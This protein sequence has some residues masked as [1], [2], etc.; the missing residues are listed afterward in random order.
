[1][2]GAS[3]RDARWCRL[4]QSL[5]TIRSSSAAIVRNTDRG[6]VPAAIIGASR[7]SSS[8]GASSSC[9][10][11]I[12]SR[13]A[14]I[15]P[16]LLSSD[17]RAARRNLSDR[18]ARAER[19]PVLRRRRRE[20]AAE[21]AA[22]GGGVAEPAAAGNVLHAR[23]AGLQKLAGAGDALVEQPAVRAGPVRVGEGAG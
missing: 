21:V 7:L 1:M 23:V 18:R 2:A 8:R 10:A 16:P 20:P 14:L 15:V 6:A 11:R 3:D 5:G 19:A 13:P 17:E 9:T 4:R 22:Q 12:R